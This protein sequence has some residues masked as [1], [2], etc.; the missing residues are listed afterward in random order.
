M[1]VSARTFL[2]N[3]YVKTS[4]DHHQLAVFP[5][6]EINSNI[7]LQKLK[8]LTRALNKEF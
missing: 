6:E 3:V 4:V 1:Q 8:Y 5:R 2:A 7:A